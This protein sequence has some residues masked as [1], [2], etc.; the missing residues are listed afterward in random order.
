MMKTVFLLTGTIITA[1]LLVSC[2]NAKSSDDTYCQFAATAVIE[3]TDTSVSISGND[4]LC[5]IEVDRT[6][7]ANQ[8]P[9]AELVAVTPVRVERPSPLEIE[10]KHIE[11]NR[12]SVRYQFE[13][14]SRK[15]FFQ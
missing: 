12:C 3:P 4:K 6:D 11:E 5:V 14:L 2:G 1:V 9:C 8:Q 7:N 15:T 13:D 10:A